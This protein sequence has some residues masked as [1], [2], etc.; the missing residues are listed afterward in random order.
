MKCKKRI[1]SAL[2][3]I[4]VFAIALIGGIGKSIP[5]PTKVLILNIVFFTNL[6]EIREGVEQYFADISAFVCTMLIS[7]IALLITNNMIVCTILTIIAGTVII[8]VF[9]PLEKA[10]LLRAN[11]VKRKIMTIINALG[12]YYAICSIL[13]FKIGIFIAIIATIIGS[14]RISQ[15]RK[16]YG[17][18]RKSIN[19]RNIKQTVEPVSADTSTWS[20]EDLD[21][22]IFDH[23]KEAEKKESSDQPSPD[24]KYL[25]IQR[26]VVRPDRKAVKMYGRVKSE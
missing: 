20:I 19:T 7:Y 5:A 16:R 17:K 1:V 11:I 3:A 15:K 6:F 12:I 25:E 24:R 2:F 14:Y 9:E 13:S 10:R 23:A 8:A 22:S 26:V 18:R 4:V 21:V